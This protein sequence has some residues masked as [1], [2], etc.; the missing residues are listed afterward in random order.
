MSMVAAIC[1]V[2]SLLAM[3]AYW[4][5]ERVR[6]A[7]RIRTLQDQ[8]AHSRNENEWL[9]GALERKQNPLTIERAAKRLGLAGLV[10][11]VPVVVVP[12]RDHSEA[13]GS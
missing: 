10:K 9:R 2:G 12:H 11:D 6:A 7:Y 8:L 4:R 13:P 1:L 3:G 5:A